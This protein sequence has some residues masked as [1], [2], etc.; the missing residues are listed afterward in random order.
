[1]KSD[2]CGFILYNKKAG[3]VELTNF[4]ARLDLEHLSLGGTSKRSNDK[5]AGYHGEGFKLAALVLRRNDH[6]VRIAASS[7]YWNFGFRRREPPHLYCRLS[8]A[9]PEKVE[10][11]KKR[12]IAK[13]SRPGFKRDLSA[14]LWEDVTVKIAK[15]RDE[16][17]LVVQEDEFR[18]WLLVTLDLNPPAPA[19]VIKT[20]HGDLLL[21]SRF[22]GSTYLKGL[23]VAGNGQEYAYGY[24]FAHGR[25]NRDRD[26]IADA[27]HEQTVLREI[28]QAAISIKGAPIID[29]YLQLLGE[30]KDCVEVT[31]TCD[32]MDLPT[33]KTIWRHMRSSKKDAYFYF[34]DTAP[35]KS[36]S[37]KVRFLC[38]QK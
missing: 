21:D 22:A 31:W 8:Q 3:S 1:M 15:G 9:K 19:E 7:F 6:S 33:V 24:N 23:R 34:E 38:H 10:Q 25:I 27:K 11:L 12:Y 30:D 17:G 37:E 26:R 32:K 14:N 5:F 13:L 20:D 35:A 16:G 28:W 18:S 36:K 2:L 4:R 29:L